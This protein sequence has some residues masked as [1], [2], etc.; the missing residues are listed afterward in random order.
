L[1]N[2][3]GCLIDLP[4]AAHLVVIRDGASGLF[5]A[6]FEFFSFA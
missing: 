3:A 1:G 4:F 2:F 5:H 6:P